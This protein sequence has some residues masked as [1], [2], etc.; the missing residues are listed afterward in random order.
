MLER[1]VNS[2]IN[3]CQTLLSK[4]ENTEYEKII[5]IIIAN[6]G[7]LIP[8]YIQDWYKLHKIGTP[9]AFPSGTSVEQKKANLKEYLLEKLPQDGE[10][11]DEKIVEIADNIGYDDDVF[12]YGGRKRKNKT[13]IK[14]VKPT[15]SRKGKKTNKIRK[16]KIKDKKTIKSRKNIQVRKIKLT[17]KNLKIYKKKAK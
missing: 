2:L 6:P 7:K 10:L 1:I 9:H 5:A 17:R 12:M 4:G 13:T 3:P 15:R 14:N 16:I 11:I 8:E